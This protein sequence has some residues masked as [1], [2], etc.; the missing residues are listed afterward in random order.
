MN[1]HDD[2]DSHE[3]HEVPGFAEPAKNQTREEQNGKEVKDK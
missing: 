1:C 3:G 2:E